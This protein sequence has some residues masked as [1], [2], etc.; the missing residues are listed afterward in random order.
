MPETPESLRHLLRTKLG[1]QKLIVVSNREP[2][3]HVYQ[4]GRVQASSN[5][6]EKKLSKLALAARDIYWKLGRRCSVASFGRAI[7]RS[8]QILT[9]P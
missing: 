7:W 3:M 2:D 1:K 5:L 4:Q 6:K 9:G 8:L